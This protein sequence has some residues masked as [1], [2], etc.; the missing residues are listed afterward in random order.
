MSERRKPSKPAAYLPPAESKSARSR[1][2]ERKQAQANYRIPGE[3]RDRVTRLADE[4]NVTTSDLA[5][6]LLEYGLERYEDGEMEI[7]PK[8]RSGKFTLYPG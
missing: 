4:L 2:W 6:F 7:E 8:P 1:E 5:R 3:L